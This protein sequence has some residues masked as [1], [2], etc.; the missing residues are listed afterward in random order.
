[1]LVSIMLFRVYLQKGLG[2]FKLINST[3]ESISKN[4][5]LNEG[6]LNKHLLIFC[7]KKKTK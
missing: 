4:S 5:L 2:I 1:M 7:T 6:K 3:M